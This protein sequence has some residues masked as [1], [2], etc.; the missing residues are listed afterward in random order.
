MLQQRQ[1]VK[2]LGKQ[3]NIEDPICVKYATTS[4]HYLDWLLISVNV[5]T[6]RTVQPEEY[7]SSHCITTAKLRSNIKL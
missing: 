7:Q 2:A 4:F 5:T 3:I 6:Y 1:I